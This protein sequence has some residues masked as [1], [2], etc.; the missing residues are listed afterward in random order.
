MVFKVDKAMSGCRR[1]KETEALK[2]GESSMEY[3]H[4]PSLLGGVFEILVK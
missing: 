4:I 2:R 3:S 1:S